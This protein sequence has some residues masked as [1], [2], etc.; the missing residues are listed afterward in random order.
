[1]KLGNLSGNARGLQ[2][3]RQQGVVAVVVAVTI[4]VMIG[5]VG[6]AIDLGRM[7]VVKTEL[8]NSADACSLAAAGGLNSELTDAIQRA[9]AAGRTVATL[10]RVGFQET[11][12]GGASTPVAITF[13][14]SAAGPYIS[15]TGLTGAQARAIRY[16]RCSVTYTGIKTYF[17]QVLNVFPGVNIGNQDVSAS[18]V[19]SQLPAQTTCAVP[20]ALCSEQ[21]STTPVGGWIGGLLAPGGQA[22]AGKKGGESSSQGNFRWVDLTPGTPGAADIASQLA[23]PGA[24]ALPALGTFVGKAG[25]MNSLSHA[26]NSRFG[27]Y[28]GSAKSGESVPDMSGFGYTVNNWP[29]RFNAMANLAEKRSQNATYQGNLG[30]A[31]AGFDVQGTVQSTSFLQT[32]GRDRRLVVAPVVNCLDFDNK[33]KGPI[34]SWA[35]V[36]L[37]HPMPSTAGGGTEFQCNDRSTEKTKLCLEYRGDASLPTSP[38][39]S[40]GLPGD[41]SGSGPVVPT[42]VK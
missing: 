22:D 9:E 12:I 16:T 11:P 6:L 33:H 26:Y 25:V 21:V 40:S 38:C 41:P 5:M 7:F 2:G 3:R 8:Q 34:Q 15:G 27:I 36:F 23:G 37:L 13:S 28:F 1:M 30:P 17:I 29:S 24:C 14:Q 18:A 35:C 19:A 42:L 10:H 32:Y 20:I 4:V 31:A 39:A